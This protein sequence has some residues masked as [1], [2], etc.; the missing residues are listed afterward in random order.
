MSWTYKLQGDPSQMPQPNLNQPIEKDLQHHIIG[1][2]QAT[3]SESIS[4]SKWTYQWNQTNNMLR[5]VDD[6]Q[7]TGF[8]NGVCL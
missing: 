5:N 3:F 6:Y 4:Q 7:D 8:S 1:F 2:H